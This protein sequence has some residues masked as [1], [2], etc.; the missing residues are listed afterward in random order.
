MFVPGGYAVLTNVGSAT[1]DWMA[2]R[3]ERLIAALAV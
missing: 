1:P 2:K 3:L